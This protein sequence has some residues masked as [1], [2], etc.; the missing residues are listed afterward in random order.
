MTAYDNVRRELERAPRTW[1]ITGVGGF[2][3]SNLLETL[4][5][6]DQRVVG[7][8]NFSTGYRRNLEEVEAS[9]APERWRNFRL[10]EGDIGSLDTCH[11]ACASVDY[12]LHEAAL[13][14]V[15]ASMEDPLACHRTN[16]TGFI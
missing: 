15:P 7:L 10:F 3:G 6:L 4:L 11:Q 2:I 1:L 9:I 14:S 16:V 8:D 12:V 5:R 13:G